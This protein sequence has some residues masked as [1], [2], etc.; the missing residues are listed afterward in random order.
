MATP[1][2]SFPPAVTPPVPAFVACP[3]GLLGWMSA[4]QAAVV[5]QAYQLAMART[6]AVLA[7]SL[8]EKLYARSV[9]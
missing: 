3:V 4:E 2:F 8:V 9:N 1:R 7:P 6:R 5:Q